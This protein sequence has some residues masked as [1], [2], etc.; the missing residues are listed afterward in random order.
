MSSPRASGQVKLTLIVE[1]KVFFLILIKFIIHGSIFSYGYEY[2][3][4]IVLWQGDREDNNVV[5]LG[6]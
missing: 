4:L 5:A 3:F 1:L 2:V 6:K